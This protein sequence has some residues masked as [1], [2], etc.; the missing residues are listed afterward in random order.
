MVQGFGVQRLE[1]RGQKSEVRDQMTDAGNQITW[2]G[3]SRNPFDSLALTIK[4]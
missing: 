4:R 3:Y 2:I 1:D